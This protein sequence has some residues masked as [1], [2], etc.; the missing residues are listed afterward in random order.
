M[1]GGKQGIASLKDR[2]LFMNFQKLKV[3]VVGM[4]RSGVAVC[5]YL[6]GRGAVVTAIDE[7][8][9]AQL[10]QAVLA[11]LRR[12]GVRL[13]SGGHHEN[14]LMGADAVV[15]SPGVPA[16]RE[17]FISVQ[18]KGIPVMGELELAY[19]V[20]RTP[21]VAITGTNGKSTVTSLVGTM[22]QH[23]GLKVFVGGNIGTPLI[24]YA[25]EGEGCEYAVVE[26]SSFQLDT[27]HL[28]SPAVAVLL[29]ISPDH[30]DRYDSY[31]AYKASKCRIF[32]NQGPGQVVILNDEDRTLAHLEPGGGASVLRYGLA[33]GSGRCATIKDGMIQ[34]A[35]PGKDSFRFDLSESTLLGK[36][37][38]ENILAAVLVGMALDIPAERLGET[39]RTFHGLP[40]RLEFVG[41]INNV[42]FVDDSK[43]TNEDAAAK[44]ISS[45]DHP[46]VL[47]AGGRHK[48]GSYESLLTAAQGRVRQ[49][50]FLG[51]AKGLL[52]GSFEGKIP[53]SLADNLSDAVAQAYKAAHE[54]DVVLLAPACSSFDMFSDYAQRG[55]IFQETVERLR[56]G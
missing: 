45:F 53:F 15:V 54:E 8:T 33:E 44:A 21:I 36:H 30:L 2:K 29:N 41:R 22:M 26:V 1:K 49:A 27:S 50:V 16:D 14:A 9:E 5:R 18:K 12:M 38:H 56:H 20:L 6:A 4:G 52:A 3:A 55:Q 37:N 10:D 17:P 11:D 31:Q 28:F 47:I 48:G 35:F 25:L 7:K 39:L 24:E 13:E 32:Q 51:E 23:A 42:S 40:H 19:R 46:V 34:A 43:A